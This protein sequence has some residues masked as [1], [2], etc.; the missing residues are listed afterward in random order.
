MQADGQ[1]LLVQAPELLKD[2]L[3]L[4][5]GI[6]EDQRCARTTESFI[7]VRQSIE[8]HVA[9]PGQGLLARQDLDLRL[10]PA[11]APYQRNLSVVFATGRQPAEQ[12]RLIS[13][14]GG[15]ADPAH[16]GRQA[17]QTRQAESEQFAALVGR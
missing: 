3:S 15:E 10:D 14:R 4:S 12:R 8:R 1:P 17:L 16:S 13:Y 6:H 11:L 9:G 2:E 7:D 5:A